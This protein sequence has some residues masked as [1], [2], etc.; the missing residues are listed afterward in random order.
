MLIK[1]LQIIA[2]VATVITGVVSTFWPRSV[3]GFTGLEPAGGRGITEIRS[4]LGAFF[5][6]LGGAVLVLND[7]EAYLMLGITYLVVALV[8]TVSMFVDKSVVRSNVI[9]AVAEVILGII[10]VL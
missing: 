7:P 4:I 1:I 10:L 6:G 5:I 8:R 3:R 9:S 2:G